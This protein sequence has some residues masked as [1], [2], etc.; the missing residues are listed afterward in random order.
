MMDLAFQNNLYNQVLHNGHIGVELI[1]KSAISRQKGKHPDGH[2]IRKLT[3]EEISGSVILLEINRD[4]ATLKQFNKIY[5]A[6]KMQYRYESISIS[7][8]EAYTYLN[9]FKGA[10][11]WTKDKYCR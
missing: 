9:A 4:I 5:T 8:N 3:R 6:W 11:K 2:E 10:Y 7:R 1:M